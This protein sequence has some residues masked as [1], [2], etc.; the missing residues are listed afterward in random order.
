M[1]DKLDIVLQKLEA[2]EKHLNIKSKTIYDNMAESY[3]IKDTAKIL[4]C[5]E[6][7][8]RQYIKYEMLDSFKIGHR[9]MI[10]SKAIKKLIKVY[11]K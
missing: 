4:G 10:K 5:S 11:S 8:V 7:K 3:S 9:R 6:T 2:I 1:M